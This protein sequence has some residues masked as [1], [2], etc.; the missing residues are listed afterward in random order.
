MKDYF[1]FYKLKNMFWFLWENLIIFR[2]YLSLWLSTFFVICYHYIWWLSTLWPSNLK[3]K[4]SKKHQRMW[5]VTW[6]TI[7]CQR[8]VI[9]PSLSRRTDTAITFKTSNGTYSYLVCKCVRNKYQ[10]SSS[11]GKEGS[12]ESPTSTQRLSK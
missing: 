12:R 9:L 8:K 11:V 7:S 2:T 1:K 5:K 6:N 3:H 10:H 4:T